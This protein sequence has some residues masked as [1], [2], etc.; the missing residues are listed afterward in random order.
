V[1][2]RAAQGVDLVVA[3]ATDQRGL[4]ATTDDFTS[5]ALLPT[6]WSTSKGGLPFI[7]NIIDK[8]APF[9]TPVAVADPAHDAFFIAD[10]DSPG[11][12]R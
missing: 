2:N 11:H 10:S 1:P 4:A 5:S 9:G 12:R 8:F 6:A 7:S 3:T